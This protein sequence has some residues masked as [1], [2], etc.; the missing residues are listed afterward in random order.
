MT[1]RTNAVSGGGLKSASCEVGVHPNSI[2]VQGVDL[3]NRKFCVF[4][5]DERAAFNNSLLYL[6]PTSNGFLEMGMGGSGNIA[7]VY[8]DITVSFN[9]TTSS[10]IGFTY[11]PAVTHSPVFPYTVYYA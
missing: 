9:G 6:I 8:S 7:T 1:G 10:I 3:R 11:M 2:D 5:V 4:L